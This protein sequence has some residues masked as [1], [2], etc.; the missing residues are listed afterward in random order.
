MD[1]RP[2]ASLK[3][4]L[5]LRQN[6]RRRGWKHAGVIVEHEQRAATRMLAHPQ[7]DRCDAVCPWGRHI[8]P[9][10]AEFG[11]EHVAQFF[12]AMHAAPGRMHEYT[13]VGMRLQKFRQLCKPLEPERSRCVQ[14][15]VEIQADDSHAQF[16][17][18]F[19][20][21]ELKPMERTTLRLAL[22]TFFCSAHGIT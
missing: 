3:P 22:R 8:D 13:H 11:R 18:G 1:C 7:A 12:N 4:M 5:L 17:S 16:V 2:S 6:R 9:P 19:Q 10:G 14:H 20:Q 21:L 15:A